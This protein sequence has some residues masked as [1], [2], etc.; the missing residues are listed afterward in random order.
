M[1]IHTEHVLIEVPK[2]QV[3]DYISDYEN[4]TRWGKNFI[5]ELKKTPEG[6]IAKTPMGE[7]TFKLEGDRKT[8]VIHHILNGSAL[9]S[10]V[11]GFGDRTLFSFTLILPPELT[12]E[13]FR[14]GVEGLREELYILKTE[15]ES[16]KR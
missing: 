2:D 13:Q 12:E 4:Q 6:Y 5:L 16:T 1:K 8:G 9:P 10:R 15:I 11:I 3:F 14:Q 7:Q